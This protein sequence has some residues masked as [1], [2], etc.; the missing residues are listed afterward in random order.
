MGFVRL[1]HLCLADLD[2]AGADVDLA[3]LAGLGGGDARLRAGVDR[4]LDGDRFFRFAL[5]PV[6]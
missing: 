6:P 5:L 3:F 1:H 2:G 4:A